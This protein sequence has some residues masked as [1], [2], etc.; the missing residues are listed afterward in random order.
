MAPTRTFDEFNNIIFDN[1][2]SSVIKHTEKNTVGS[3]DEKKLIENMNRKRNNKGGANLDDSGMMLD[4]DESTPN[5]ERTQLLYLGRE[6][7]Q[8]KQTSTTNYTT[9]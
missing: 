6:Q 3:I 8:A 2:Q 1:E 4:V 9:H 5:S 7:Q